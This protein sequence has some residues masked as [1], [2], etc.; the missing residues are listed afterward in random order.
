MLYSTIQSEDILSKNDFINM[1]LPGVVW[2]EAESSGKE[3]WS[4]DTICRPRVLEWRVVKDLAVVAS[5]ILII[6]H[7][8]KKKVS[9]FL[10]QHLYSNR[11]GT[12]E[13]SGKG[14]WGSSY[15]HLLSSSKFHLSL[16]MY[17][18]DQKL[19]P[20]ESAKISSVI[21]IFGFFWMQKNIANCSVLCLD[22]LRCHFRYLQKGDV[23]KNCHTH[24]QPFL[25]PRSHHERCDH[26]RQMCRHCPV[27]NNKHSK[28]VCFVVTFSTSFHLWEPG[29]IDF[30]FAC[31]HWSVL[32]WKT[33]KKQKTKLERIV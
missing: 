9:S 27:H 29:W 21:T 30:Y 11:T 10:T 3:N 22:L 5:L 12:E 17:L 7:L 31:F 20:S 1:V 6:L 2:Q 33:S 28:T 8:K 13:V 26:W 4:I 19:F 18:Q 25:P 24:Q 14:A 23:R 15:T 16:E 32:L